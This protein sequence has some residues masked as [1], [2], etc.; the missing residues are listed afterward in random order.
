MT[1]VFEHRSHPGT[2]S[3]L[4]S[5]LTVL[6][7]ILCASAHGSSTLTISVKDKVLHSIDHRVFGQFM[8][9]PA[10]G[11]ETGPEAAVV[12]GT[13][14][15]QPL[16]GQ[17][18]R[19]MRIP[20]L[21]FPGGTDVDFIDWTDMI[22]NAP[23][24]KDA[25]RP[26]SKGY[27]GDEVSNAFGYDE[28][29]Q[30]CE[31]DGSEAILVVNL[32]DALLQKKPVA[33][34]A[35][36][37]AGLIAYCAAPL[38]RELPGNLALWPKLRAQNG[39]LKPY[40]VEYVQIGNETWMFNPEAERQLGK[41]SVQHWQHCLEAYIDA[42]HAA[43]PDAKFIVDAFP[44]PVSKAIHEKYGDLITGYG[45]HIYHPWGIP[46]VLKGEELIAR[47][48]LTQE[49]IWKAWT[50]TPRVDARGQA[51]IE[52][53]HLDHVRQ[54]GGRVAM[55]EWNWNGWWGPGDDKNKIALD[56]QYARGI[57][58]ASLL[59]AILRKADLITLAT[60]SML[61]GK[62]W[63][64]TAIR[65]DPDNRVPAFMMP[66]GMVT[67]LYSQNSGNE[68]LAV[69]IS[70]AEFYNQPFKMSGLEPNDRIACVDVL[71]TKDKGKL[72]VHMINRRFSGEQQVTVDC[73]D[74]NLKPQEM[75]IVVMEGRLTDQPGE[76]ESLAPAQIYQR[77]I[78]FDGEL[79][80]LTL[81]P[82]AIVFAKFSLRKMPD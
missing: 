49:E 14:E 28:F 10:F 30:L 22:D 21:R 54:F 1:S 11:G 23:G 16:A 52:D 66:S 19:E 61:V 46:K 64:I 56:S 80:T 70:G 48:S 76:G 20:V 7:V 41:N 35:A 34:A 36:H 50:V 26:P 78:P 72:V 53:G 18:I 39:R 8:E 60:Q 69:E 38:D 31:R 2:S 15:L 9:R 51:V 24:R 57:G 17:L 68:L 75:E 44:W 40:K 45:V 32:R 79:L 82:R 81:P 3:S 71:A 77:K 6:A 27:R 25:G 67:S 47:S 4:V 42:I 59:H 29:L 13:H 63:Q 62:R 12:P 37:A 55:T 33:E 5:A 65:V 58:A 73:K 74:F 43:H